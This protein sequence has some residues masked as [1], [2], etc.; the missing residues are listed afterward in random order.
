MTPKPTIKFGMAGIIAAGMMLT[1][2]E[3]T[4]LDGSTG[5]VANRDILGGALGAAGGYLACK[6][7]D[8]NNTTCALAALGGAAAGVVISRRLKQEDK[9]PRSVALAEVVEGDATS[10]SWASADTGSKGTIT[11]VNSSTGE[12]GRPCRTVEEVYSIRGEDSITE[13]F[14]LCQSGDGTW[15]TVV[16]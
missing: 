6:A 2:C 1:A 8:G 14:T 3:T 9:A 13:Q 16:V 10:K 7:L 5:G 12:A 11:L 15:E 4:S